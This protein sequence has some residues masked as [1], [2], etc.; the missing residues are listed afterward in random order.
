[1]NVT[2]CELMQEKSELYC[3]SVLCPELLCATWHNVSIVIC[4]HTVDSVLKK[5]YCACSN[6]SPSYIIMYDSYY[7]ANLSYSVDMKL[8]NCAILAFA[9]A[10]YFASLGI[11]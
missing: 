5:R 6:F 10:W 3:L 4:P 11:L 9:I 2:S 8:L 1:M 7:A